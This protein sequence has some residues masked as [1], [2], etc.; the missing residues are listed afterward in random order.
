MS[1][2]VKVSCLV[3]HSFISIIITLAEPS[4]SSSLGRLAYLYSHFEGFKVHD[5]FLI[6]SV[7]SFLRVISHA[8]RVPCRGHSIVLYYM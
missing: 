8:G 3:R 2:F 1:R 4:V 7:C 6:I 5:K